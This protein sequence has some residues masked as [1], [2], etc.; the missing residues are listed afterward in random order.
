MRLETKRNQK[1]W[2]ASKFLWNC[3]QW[4]WFFPLNLLSHLHCDEIRCS[5]HLSLLRLFG[6]RELLPNIYKIFEK[7]TWLVQFLKRFKYIIQKCPPQ[8][9]KPGTHECYCCTCKSLQILLPGRCLFAFDQEARVSWQDYVFSGQLFEFKIL[10]FKATLG[11]Y[12]VLNN[13]IK[14]YKLEKV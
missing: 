13:P 4:L 5:F 14:P 11:Y 3:F 8:I 2:T 10:N 6:I 9:L 1:Y 12:I 7:G